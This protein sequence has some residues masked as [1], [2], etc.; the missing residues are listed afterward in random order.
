M[1]HSYYKTRFVNGSQNNNSNKNNYIQQNSASR[2]QGKNCAF[3]FQNKEPSRVYT[4]HELK[5]SLGNV[6]C[7]Q[8]AKH[9]CEVCGAT[10]KMAHTRSYCPNII[11]MRELCNSS[12]QKSSSSSITTLPIG[13]TQSRAAAISAI[14]ATTTFAPSSSIANSASFSSSNN[15]TTSSTYSTYTDS[16]GF[17]KS[18][19]MRNNNNNNYNTDSCNSGA[20]VEISRDRRFRNMGQLTSSRY[21]S[22]GRLRRQRPTTTTTTTSTNGQQN[23]I[24]PSNGNHHNGFLG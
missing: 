16:I 12:S 8:L 24:R 20:V 17:Y 18:Q 1:A 15:S 7:P 4:S 22:A 23:P 10:G 3:C 13:L 2:R 5:D 19:S 11:A 14:A 9:V 21:N 6:T